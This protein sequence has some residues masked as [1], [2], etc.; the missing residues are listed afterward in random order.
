MNNI[1][2]NHYKCSKIVKK[3]NGNE[4]DEDVEEKVE[5]IS[6]CRYR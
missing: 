2:E 5:G 4:D 6:C 1:N 3:M